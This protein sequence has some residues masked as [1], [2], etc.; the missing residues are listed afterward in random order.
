MKMHSILMKHKRF[1]NRLPLKRK[2]VRTE[3]IRHGTIKSK[4]R[5]QTHVDKIL[6]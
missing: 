3:C 4:H 6:R 5:M 2:C 1:L